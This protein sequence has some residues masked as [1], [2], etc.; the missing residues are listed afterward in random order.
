MSIESINALY[1]SNVDYKEPT[2]DKQARELAREAINEAENAGHNE[3]AKEAA[4]QKLVFYIP[5]FERKSTQGRAWVIAAKMEDNHEKKQALINKAKAALQAD[6][7]FSSFPDWKSI[8]KMELEMG[9]D[10]SVTFSNMTQILDDKM[11][12]LR[13][14]W[15]VRSE[16]IETTFSRWLQLAEL[17]ESRRDWCLG[18]AR[19]VYSMF[20]ASLAQMGAELMLAHVES[21]KSEE[22]GK[23]QTELALAK[24]SNFKDTLFEN[25]T[26]F[27]I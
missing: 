5:K 24:A 27:G 11:A 12:S 10:T 3:Q 26:T 18:Q 6:K 19:S 4:L 22:A 20:K 14:S 16:E 15:F 9:S 21:K 2:D 1:S 23:K 25:N 13:S 8:A 17:H 7:C